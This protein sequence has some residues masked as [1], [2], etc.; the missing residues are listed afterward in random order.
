MLVYAQSVACM[1]SVY[2]Q[3]KNIRFVK[4]KFKNG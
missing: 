2:G 4:T 1:P 3:I